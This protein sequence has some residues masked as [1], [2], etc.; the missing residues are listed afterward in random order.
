MFKLDLEKAEESEIKLPTQM[1][2]KD[3]FF[4]FGTSLRKAE[5]IKK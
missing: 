4:F 5:L 2:N 1:G 3:F